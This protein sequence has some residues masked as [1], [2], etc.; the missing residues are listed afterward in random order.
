M[1]VWLVMGA[2]LGFG[3]R[4][5][6]ARSIRRD[7]SYIRVAPP[8]MLEGATAAIFAVLAWR[9]S[10]V[11][12]LM[13]YGSLAAVGVSL[14]ALDVAV[15]RLPNSLVA[16]AY[17]VT[18]GF[19]I[20]AALTSQTHGPLLRALVA[21]PIGLILFG[22]LYILLP[23]QL[24]GGDLKLAGVLALALGWWS[25]TAALTGMLLGWALAAGYVLVLRTARTPP[26][27]GVPLGP[28]LI[29]GAFIE[30]ILSA[31]H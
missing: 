27:A 26:D 17:L 14:A 25:W 15:R 20:I 3:A 1:I 29:S 28:F 10:S 5:A 8:L 24:G 12:V 18:V 23:G 2:A 22:L 13:A 16:T 19:L 6:A 31:Y 21:L 11:P 30:I 7:V 9:I 4:R